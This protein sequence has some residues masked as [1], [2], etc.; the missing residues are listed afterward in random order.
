M[1]NTYT[2]NNNK[3]NKAVD[4]L[5]DGVLRGMGTSS[6]QLRNEGVAGVAGRKIAYKVR[7]KATVYARR[8]YN[9]LPKSAQ[10]GFSVAA[11]ALVVVCIIGWFI[12]NRQTDVEGLIRLGLNYL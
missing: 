5:V 8:T 1:S 10:V 4:Q 3:T 6:Y 12:M 7:N 9:K 11:V 2:N